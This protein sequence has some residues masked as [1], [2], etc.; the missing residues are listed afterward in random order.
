MVTEYKL[1]ISLTPNC[2]PIC[3][4]FIIIIIFEIKPTLQTHYL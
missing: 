1:E 4:F 2:N 3:V